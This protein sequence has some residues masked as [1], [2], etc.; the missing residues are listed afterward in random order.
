MIKVIFSVHLIRLSLIEAKRATHFAARP[1]ALIELKITSHRVSSS[2][3][4]NNDSLPQLSALF[5][6]QTNKVSYPKRLL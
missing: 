4:N 2:F 3:F 1:A 5:E 6:D